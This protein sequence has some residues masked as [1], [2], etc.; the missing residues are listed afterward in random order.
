M[1]AQEEEDLASSEAVAAEVSKVYTNYCILISQ[2]A[3]SARDWK[4]WLDFQAYSKY[5]QEMKDNKCK[6]M[7][8]R[9]KT[10]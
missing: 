2:V 3:F 8:L 1:V 9:L 7:M 6:G 10:S 4:E 5:Y